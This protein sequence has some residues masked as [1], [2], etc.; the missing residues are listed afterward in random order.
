MGCNM[1]QAQALSGLLSLNAWD[2]GCNTRASR[3]G[4]CKSLPK[5]LKIAQS[6]FPCS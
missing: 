2:V 1:G 5:Q 3:H 4:V 6:K